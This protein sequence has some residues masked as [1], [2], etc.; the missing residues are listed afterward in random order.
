MDLTSLEAP[1]RESDGRTLLAA[2]I[3]DESETEPLTV[4]EAIALFI[5]VVLGIR[6]IVAEHISKPA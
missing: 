5:Q 6:R 1:P 2:I 4:T 3:D